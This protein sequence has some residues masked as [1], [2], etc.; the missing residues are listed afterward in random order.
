MKWA[1]FRMLLFGLESA[2]QQTLDKIGKG[3]KVED[4]KYIIKAAKCGLD[5]HVAVM[6]GYPWETDSDS[7]NTLKL[8]HYLLRKGFAKTAQA[9]FY[10]V[11]EGQS[12][13]SHRRFINNIYNVCYS[14]EFWFNQIRDIK[15]AS[16]LK[17]LWRKIK[18]GLKEWQ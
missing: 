5:P 6:F 14:P 4:V 8:V 10:N 2:N 15:D 9:S 12:N 11:G 1:G 7:I 16:D 18:T 13:P 17:Y 3:T